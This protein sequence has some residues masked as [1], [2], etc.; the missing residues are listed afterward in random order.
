MRQP[1][2]SLD[3]GTLKV[4]EQ[5]IRTITGLNSEGPG[6]SLLDIDSILD[7]RSKSLIAFCQEDGY[8]IIDLRLTDSEND[9]FSSIKLTN[10]D[11]VPS[12]SLKLAFSLNSWAKLWSFDEYWRELLETGQNTT[13]LPLFSV[14]TRDEE[15]EALNSYKRLIDDSSRPIDNY[16]F[17]F[18]NTAEYNG[19]S[20][21]SIQEL[22]DWCTESFVRLHLQ[23][24]Y[25]LKAKLNPFSLSLFF[26]FPPEFKSTCSQYLH[27]F[28]KFLE[29]QGVQNQLSVKEEEGRTI[30]QVTPTDQDHALEEIGRQLAVYLGLPEQ[31]LEPTAENSAEFMQLQSQV[32]FFKGQFEMQ[33]GMLQAKDAHLQSLESIVGSQTQTIQQLHAN[34]E[35]ASRHL[36]ARDAS[37]TSCLVQSLEAAQLKGTRVERKGLAHT[38][39]Q[40]LKAGNLAQTFFTGIDVSP[41]LTLLGFA[42]DSS[43]DNCD[44]E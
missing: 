40:W 16:W 33:K 6:L 29:D 32:S 18:H 5:E 10:L 14:A 27:Y 31:T 28:G 41:V 38:F 34:Q 37:L 24:I 23:T 1:K 42:E 30:L 15:E 43:S 4:N 9:Y 22:I 36:E 3:R 13:V 19:V 44:A 17:H 7:L 39:Q 11:N 8:G 12:I 26:D 21:L 35:R 25:T 20:D 2:I